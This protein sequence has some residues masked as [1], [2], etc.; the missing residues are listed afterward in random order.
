MAATITHY[1]Y[2]KKFLV[3][4][5]GI[6][7]V[8]DTIKLALCTS[9]YTPDIDTHDYFD[10]ITNELSGGGYT[11]GGNTLDNFSLTVDT[12]NDRLKIDADDESFTSLTGTNVRYGI[13]YKS[14]GTAS[15][16]PLIAYVDFGE[17]KTFANGTLTFTWHSNGVGLIT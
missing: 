6:D 7:L 17:N 13:I 10:N 15:T 14:T 12:T 4:G 9:S 5:S 1:N 2:F 8:N 16:S 11:S 3:D